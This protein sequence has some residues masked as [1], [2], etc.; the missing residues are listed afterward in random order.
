MVE[1]EPLQAAAYAERLLT[2]VVRRNYHAPNTGL[3]R[4]IAA[5]KTVPMLARIHMIRAMREDAR[6]LLNEAIDDSD[7]VQMPL[8]EIQ[9]A[10]D[11]L[12][13]RRHV[14]EVSLP[15]EQL[16]A[17]RELLQ[18]EVRDQ[19]NSALQE[20]DEVSKL[21]LILRSKVLPLAVAPPSLSVRAVVD[22]LPA[23]L[24]PELRTRASRST[25]RYWRRYARG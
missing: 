21:T 23:S 19:V 4:I 20:F 17:R 25:M 10:I 15:L 13:G 24:R 5:L 7:I 11:F 22:A 16:I 1:C 14:D 2:D 6:G 8:T 18:R 9:E 3:E 12:Q